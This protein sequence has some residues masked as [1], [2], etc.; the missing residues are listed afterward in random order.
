MISRHTLLLV[1]AGCG[2]T[3]SL[4]LAIPRPSAQ[5]GTLSYRIGGPARLLAEPSP[6][7]V[8]DSTAIIR[9]DATSVAGTPTRIGIVHYG[10][11]PRDLDGTARSPTRW[12]SALPTMVFRVYLR[13]L[14]PA[15]TYYF[16]VDSA[17]ASGRPDA[18]DAPVGRFTTATADQP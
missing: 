3:V 8:S 12:N 13:D 14:R 1:S 15:T 9:W 10:T 7:L 16:T 18:L 5:H 4:C 17:Q 2:L 6:E 11:D